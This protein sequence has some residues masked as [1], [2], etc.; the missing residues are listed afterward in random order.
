MAQARAREVSHKDFGQ[1]MPAL[2]ANADFAG[3]FLANLSAGMSGG[4]G[5]LFERLLGKKC[6]GAGCSGGCSGGSCG[7]AGGGSWRGAPPG[8]EYRGFGSVAPGLGGPQVGARTVSQP[9]TVAAPGGMLRP[10]PGLP[11]A[12]AGPAQDLGSLFQNAKP[13]S[14]PMPGHNHPA[15]KPCVGPG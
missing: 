11:G 13:A 2:S 12:S 5:S 10:S 15:E 14:A 8:M 7:G 6:S 9:G 3:P 1:L 4:G